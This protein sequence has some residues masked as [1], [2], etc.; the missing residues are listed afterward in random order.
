[1]ALERT[2]VFWKPIVPLLA[3]H[4][5]VLVVNAHQ[6]TTES[7]G[8]EWMTDLLHHG[9]AR[10]SFLPPAWQRIVRERTR[11][12]ASLSHERTLASDASDLMG[13]SAQDRLHALL[14]GE[15]TPEDMAAPCARRE[16]R[17][18]RR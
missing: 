9:L 7:T 13:Q 6:S 14:E 18:D 12:R 17:W 5:D 15:R 10:P 11:S 2:G 3:G 4:L 16:N 1:V 8:A